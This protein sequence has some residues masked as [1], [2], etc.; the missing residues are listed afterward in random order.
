MEIT[1]DSESHV[2]RVDGRKVDSVTTILNILDVYSG[3][4]QRHIDAAGELGHNVHL[5]TELYDRGDLDEES[6]DP[7]LFSFLEGYKN[8]QADTGVKILHIEQIV[9]SIIHDYI[10]TL[11]R[12]VELNGQQGVLD[13]KST[14]FQ[15]KTY[16]LQVAAYERAWIET[17]GGKAPMNR[18]TLRLRPNYPKGYKLERHDGKDDFI[19]FLA[20]LTVHNLKK[21]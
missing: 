2:Y 21:E 3:V 16:P 20:C 18:Y 5:T 9:Y 11:D 13:I 10:G 4:P 14:D 6:L 1:F 19:K 7:L 17:G 12:I 8:F 15:S